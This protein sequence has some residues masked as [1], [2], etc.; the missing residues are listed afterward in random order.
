M[1]SLMVGI[2]DDISGW[3]QHI[4]HKSGAEKYAEH[5]GQKGEVWHNHFLL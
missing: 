5:H 4:L 2:R 3:W 1:A